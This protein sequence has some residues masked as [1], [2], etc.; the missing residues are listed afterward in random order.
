MTLLSVAVT[1][2][3]VLYA[4]AIGPLVQLLLPRFMVPASVPEAA[5]VRGG[6]LGTDPVDDREREDGRKPEGEPEPETAAK[7]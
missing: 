5:P 1:L 4:L 2:T 7:R 3:L 6:D